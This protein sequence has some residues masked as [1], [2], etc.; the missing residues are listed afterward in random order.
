MEEFFKNVQPL[1]RSNPERVIMLHPLKSF[2]RKSNT[3]QD[4][5]LQERSQSPLIKNWNEFGIP[6]TKSKGNCCE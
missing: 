4:T 1:N 2:T 3:R 6:K 5:A